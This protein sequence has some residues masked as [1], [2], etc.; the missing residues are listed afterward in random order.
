MA[1]VKCK[2]CGD[3]VARDA[4]TCPHCGIDSPG[5]TAL[6]K[7][8]ESLLG[9]FVLAVVILALAASCSS[10]PEVNA[11]NNQKTT[12]AH[13]AAAEKK[14]PQHL[15]KKSR[16]YPNG[17]SQILA[18]VKDHPKT[19]DEWEEISL[20]LASKY[21]ADFILIT[22]FNDESKLRNW[23]GTGGPGSS[24]WTHWLGGMLVDSN[25]ARGFA[26]MLI[27]AEMPKQNIVKAGH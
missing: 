2:I 26:G 16:R 25:G 5:K 11:N 4:K 1:L 19:M 15:F 8:G 6:R 27:N 12:E 9:V 3:T 13:P 18:I 21:D 20:A 17:R 22:Y 7:L 10:Q 23:D 24:D 14:L